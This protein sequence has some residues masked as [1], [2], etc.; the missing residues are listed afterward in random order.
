MANNEE[1]AIE[2]P[3]AIDDLN[4][5]SRVIRKVEVSKNRF[6]SVLFYDVKPQTVVSQSMT[7]IDQSIT[8]FEQAEKIAEDIDS[9]HIRIKEHQ[10]VT[11]HLEED[12]R[13]GLSELAEVIA[14]L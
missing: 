12:T 7:E 1:Q 10:A 4:L 3:S 9:V 14:A 6:R 13:R 5:I 2:N 11:Q 8:E